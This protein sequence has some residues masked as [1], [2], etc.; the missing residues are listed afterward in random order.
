VTS[1]S[2]S[3]GKGSKKADKQVQ[4]LST[5]ITEMIKATEYEIKDL[6]IHRGTAT[7]EYIRKNIQVS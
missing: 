1:G 3:P 5:A 7:D 4:H 6:S 2:T